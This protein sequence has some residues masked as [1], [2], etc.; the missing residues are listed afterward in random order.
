MVCFSSYGF[1]THNKCISNFIIKIW[2]KF[3]S[4]LSEKEPKIR[5]RNFW[6]LWFWGVEG[7]EKV[8]S[9]ENSDFTRM[10]CF[11]LNLIQFLL[12][13]CKSDNIDMVKFNYFLFDIK[14]NCNL[15]L[16]CFLGIELKIFA[17]ICCWMG[18]AEQFLYFFQE[19]PQN[20]IQKL[21]SNLLAPFFP[22]TSENSFNFQ[23]KTNNSLQ[24]PI[25]CVFSYLVYKNCNSWIVIKF[26]GLLM[27]KFYCLWNCKDIVVLGVFGYCK[28]DVFN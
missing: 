3:I 4:N 23:S 13:N 10:R 18:D 27:V 25:E 5:H 8:L 22:R 17:F 7:W 12:Q 2:S 11:L 19:N 16:Y 21:N 20:L 26:Y 28:S 14:D 15:F 9:F 1:Y 24:F 6:C